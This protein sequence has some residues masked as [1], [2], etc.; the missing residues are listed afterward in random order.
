MTISAPRSSAIAFSEPYLAFGMTAI[1]TR[2]AASSVNT[3]ADL[4]N[5]TRISYGLVRGGAT[6]HWFSTTTSAVY[7]R[8]WTEISKDAGRRLLSSLE[9]GVARVRQSDGRFAF[10]M[11]SST[12][13]YWAGRR[14]CRLATVGSLRERQH[15]GLATARASPILDGINRALRALR[16]SGELETLKSKWWRSECNAAPAGTTAAAA[17]TAATLLL[18]VTCSLLVKQ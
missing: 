15:Y 5:Q 2:A 1:M 3:F 14:P 9:E 12:A 18:S 13:Q 17:A 16:N 8:M 4:A 6:E 7:R 10:I 11:E